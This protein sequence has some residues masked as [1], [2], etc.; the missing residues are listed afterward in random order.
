MAA[1]GNW[2]LNLIREGRCLLR[3]AGSLLTV[4]RLTHC[5]VSL[6]LS[7]CGNLSANVLQ[8]ARGCLAALPGGPRK[9]VNHGQLLSIVASTTYGH[10]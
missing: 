8:I 10:K 5:T 3:P 6:A 4:S 9:S 2:S 1:L 7:T